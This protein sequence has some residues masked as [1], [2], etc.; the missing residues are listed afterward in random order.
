MQRAVFA[1]RR[2]FLTYRHG[3]AGEPSEYT[4]DPYG[5]VS[6]AGVWYLVADLNGEPRLF[7][8]DRAPAAAVL[9]EPVRHRPGLGLAGVWTVLRDRVENLPE[10]VRVHIR[11]RRSHLDV[12][13]RLHGSRVAVPAAPGGAGEWAELTLVFPALQAAR[14]LLPFGADVEIL[15][16]P[17][18]RAELAGAA[19]EVTRLYG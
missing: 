12:L 17:E 10:D 9:D 15:T 16:P 13:L 14:A 7:R 19:A 8:V 11:V 6:K 3:G 1:D 5:L 18:A 4:V 2:V